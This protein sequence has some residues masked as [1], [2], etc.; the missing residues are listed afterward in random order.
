M[1]DFLGEIL[2]SSEAFLVFSRYRATGL[3]QVG[4]KHRFGEGVLQVCVP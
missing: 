1:P 4:T 2:L 3:L